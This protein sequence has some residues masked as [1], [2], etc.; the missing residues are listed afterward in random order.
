[1][2]KNGSV[3]SLNYYGLI[4]VILLFLAFIVK[5]IYISS[6][7][8][9]DGVDIKAVAASR[10]TAVRTLSAS[11]GTIYSSNDE[12]LAKNVN[13]YI[14][15]AYI[16]P[17]RT[18]NPKYPQ[19]VV[20]KEYTAEVLS[21]YLNMTSEYILKLLNY[22]GYQVELRPGGLNISEKLKQEIEAL[23][24]PGIDFIAS[25][26]RYYPF[27]DFASYIIGYAKKQ[28]DGT[29][30]GELG[31]ES[32]FN[33]EL[34]GKNG[35]TKYE[36][37]AYGYKIADTPVIREEAKDGLDIYLTIDSNIQ[38]YLEN[39]LNDLSNHYKYEW[40]TVSIANAKTGAILG[41]ASTPSFN[42][43]ILNITSWN[44]PLVSYAY[45]PGSTMKI[46]S[47]MA[48]IE[49]GIYDGDKKYK[50]GEI[51]IGKNQVND[52]N[53]VG[54]G[55]ITY[56][57]GFAY[58]SNVAA[59]NLGLT[60]GK[61]ILVDY[62]RKCGF[63][64][65]TGIEMSNEYSGVVNPKYEI[66]IA[67]VSF[68]QGLTTT[69]IQNLQALTSLANGG[70]VLKPYIVEKIV[71]HDTNEVVYESKIEKLGRAVS[72]STTKKMLELMYDVVN[73]DDKNASG[74]VYKTV[75][76]TL[77]GKTGTAQIPSKKGGYESGTYANIRSFAGIFPYEDPEY[78][79][80]ISVKKL[81][82]G[83][84]AIGKEVKQIVE[85]I[86]K[87]KNL[88]EL[89]VDEDTT[90]IITMKNYINDN[91]VDA[92]VELEKLGLNVISI[93]DGD[94]VIDQFPEKGS[95]V[96]AG[97]KVFIK[98]NS[99]NIILPNMI[100]WNSTDAN[101]YCSLVGLNCIINGYGNVAKQSIEAEEPVG[102]DSVLELELS[103]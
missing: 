5:L 13:S 25:T 40:A 29:I 44:A 22:K 39:A 80:Y 10:K 92:S 4:A 52:W 15:I 65:K 54:W 94:R 14:V 32:Y 50:S 70:I 8:K 72:A 58:S 51:K 55:E 26:K 82:G 1:M 37:D 27:G 43:N 88:D 2:K 98:T 57:K 64:S 45:E 24:L 84:S 97:N 60:L 42:P 68:G 23:D 87:Y 49:E 100:G 90:K 69:P 81:Q 34:T 59:T 36:Q 46:F 33:K 11:R 74:R 3:I 85:S 95:K 30:Q 101:S 91:S 16:S 31:V 77:A 56:D 93:G 71:D 7:D 99:S 61:D 6:A 47:F 83:S 103:R 73:S 53:K 12:T 48:A 78:I 96:I 102:V 35:Y 89:V 63:G 67:N 19:H 41:S 17:A 75:N 66:E 79:I 38:M 28:D 20:E 86:A 18:T 76:T 21:K 9:V 62:Y